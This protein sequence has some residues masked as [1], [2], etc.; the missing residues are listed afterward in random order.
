MKVGYIRK[1]MNRIRKE[2]ESSGTCPTDL[3]LTDEYTAGQFAIEYL[4]G[5]YTRRAKRQERK[6]KNV[7]DTE[8]E[9]AHPNII[10]EGLRPRPMP[11]KRKK[12][13]HA[14]TSIAENKQISTFLDTKST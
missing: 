9:E 11:N 7:D 4:V 2:Y 3:K 13:S 1:L 14:A 10:T 12:Q 5:N 6:R 8:T